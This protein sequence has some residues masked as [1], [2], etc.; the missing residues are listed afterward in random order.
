M[1][2]PPQV[3][4]AWV[5]AVVRATWDAHRYT[6]GGSADDAGIGDLDVRR[7]IAVNPGQWRGDLRAFF[8]QHYPG[9]EYRPVEAATPAALGLVLHGEDSPPTESPSALRIGL[10]DPGEQGGA[11]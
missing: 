8:A 3:G 2:L 6:I 9:V 7:V 1:L 10:N 4:S 5:D 11:Q